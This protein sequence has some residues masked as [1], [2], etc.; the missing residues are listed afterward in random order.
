MMNSAFSYFITCDKSA[1]VCIVANV[2]ELRMS[3]NQTLGLVM[4]SDCQWGRELPHPEQKIKQRAGR[5]GV[6][7]AEVERR[8]QI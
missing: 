2:A 3:K 1:A 6:S 4:S 5:A 7:S 8:L